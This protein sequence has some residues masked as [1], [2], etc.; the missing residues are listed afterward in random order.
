MRRYS[1]PFLYCV[2]MFSTPIM[3]EISAAPAIH[4]EM[5]YAASEQVEEI[6][7]AK[8]DKAC[9]S[10]TKTLERHMDKYPDELTDQQRKYRE[11]LQRRKEK[12]CS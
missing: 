5:Q 8:R 6:E 1:L 12:F 3:A 9:K 2:T 4:Y 7:K 11:Q 10:V